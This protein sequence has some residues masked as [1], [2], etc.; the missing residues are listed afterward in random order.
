MPELLET[1]TSYVPPPVARHF[2]ADP[3]PLTAPVGERFPAAVFF[4][5]ISGFTE[6]TETLAEQGPQGA[7]ELT[8]LLN[9]YFGRLINLISAQ[10]GE[11]VKFAGDALLAVWPAT[12]EDLATVT[13]RA[14]HCGLVIQ[15]MLHDY[16]ATAGIHLSLPIG[17]GVGD[18]FTAYLGGV[19]GRWEYLVAGN[20]LVEDRCSGRKLAGGYVRLTSMKKPV[21]LRTLHPL[22]LRPEME[23]AL[24]AYIPGAIIARISA[25]QSGWLAELRRV[26]VLFIHLP[27]LDYRTPVEKGQAITQS[28]QTALYRY[29]GS[30]N[31]LNVDD[32]GTTLVAALGLPPLSHEDDPARG[33]LAAVAIMEE[34]KKVGLHG[35]VGVTTGRAFCGSVGNDTR[36]EYTMIGDVVNLAARLMVAAK[37]RILCD[38]ATYAATQEDF[39]YEVLPPITLKGKSRPAAIFRPVSEVQSPLRAQT[40]IIGRV[41]ERAIL[42]EHIQALLRGSPGG[43]IIIEGEPGIGKSRLVEDLRRQADALHVTAFLGGG[44]AIERS[45]PYHAWRGVFNGLLDLEWIVEPEMKRLHLQNILE[46]EPK[47]AAHA[48]LLNQVLGVDLAETPE[49]EELSAKGR[50][51]ATRDYMLNLLHA[52]VIRSPKLVILEDAHWLDSASWALL[53]GVSKKVRPFLLVLATR[54]MT[55]PLPPEY[56]QL[57]ADPE[58]HWLRL[59]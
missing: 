36:R 10:A 24:R 55:D 22:H 21:R 59:G 44:D 39:D 54:P 19:F 41:Q 42:A 28:L 5:D 34:L 58:I 11:V 8:R 50:V 47:V 35:S 12:E 7:E 23:N 15:E 31:K 46:L 25:G 53:L 40:M 32:K 14:V 9:D 56:S 4:A 18:A 2:A 57:V 27:D 37:G 38:E 13:A 52:S 48:P 51:E 17:I 49:T 33:V 3:S 43:V 16:E 1:L 20:P 6:L 30:I 45:T 26:T 29:E